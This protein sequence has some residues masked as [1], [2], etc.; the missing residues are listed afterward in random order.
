V[1]CVLVQNRATRFIAGTEVCY[2][3]RYSLFA[4]LGGTGVDGGAI[5]LGVDASPVFVFDSLFLRCSAASG[6]AICCLRGSLEVLRCC[7][8][9]C[10][11]EGGIAVEIGGLTRPFSIEMSNIFDCH[12]G[13]W[14]LIRLPAITELSLSFVNISKIIRPGNSANAVWAAHS[15]A[16]F[17]I[18]YSSLVG[19]EGLSLLRSFFLDDHPALEFCNLYNNT[20]TESLVVTGG[21]ALRFDHC[22]FAGN[23]CP[24]YF[25]GGSVSGSILT[26]CVFDVDLPQDE[27]L[28]SSANVKYNAVTSSW[29]LVHLESCYDPDPMAS[30]TPTAVFTIY[31]PPSRRSRVLFLRSAIFMFPF[32]LV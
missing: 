31:W 6:G 28:A 5:Y 24:H 4:D 12:R 17:Y 32:W 19:S 10:Q 21:W 7:V 15:S 8:E 27:T 29:S 13:G 14:T 23:V 2:A 20:A 3:I 11:A 26:N 25:T 9:D 16:G 22:I 30:E 18:F 1:D